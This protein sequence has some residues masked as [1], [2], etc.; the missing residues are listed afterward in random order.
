M[1]AGLAR[2]GEPACRRGLGGSRRG[3][4]RLVRRRRSVGAAG[5]P[6]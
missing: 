4:R 3:G 6:T 1:W 2:A 5:A